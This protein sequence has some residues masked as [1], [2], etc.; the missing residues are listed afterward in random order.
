MD[1][2]TL[3]TKNFAYNKQRFLLL[4]SYRICHIQGNTYLMAEFMPFL[5]FAHTL[6]NFALVFGNFDM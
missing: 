4:R 5:T 1:K 3:A 2:L 6:F